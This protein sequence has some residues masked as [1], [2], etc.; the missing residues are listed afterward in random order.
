M[1]ERALQATGILSIHITRRHTRPTVIT[2]VTT[3][4]FMNINI[5]AGEPLVLVTE[6]HHMS[7]GY[8]GCL[9]AFSTTPGFARLIYG[10][11]LAR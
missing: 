10:L 3:L 2:I 1:V 4:W 5:L 8:D 6:G 9:F 7:R 11:R